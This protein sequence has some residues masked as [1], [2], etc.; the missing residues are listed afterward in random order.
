MYFRVEG[1]NSDEIAKVAGNAEIICTE[2]NQTAFV[3]DAMTIK[4]A[5]EVSDKLSANGGK[6]VSLIPVLGE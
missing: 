3:T 4:S 2:N 6:V 5:E 1:V